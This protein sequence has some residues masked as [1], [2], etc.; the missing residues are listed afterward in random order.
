[1]G[2]ERVFV[3]QGLEELAANG[4]YAGSSISVISRNQTDCLREQ[5][6]HLILKDQRHS[7]V[8]YAYAG[9]FTTSTTYSKA[10]GRILEGFAT[11]LYSN[12]LLFAKPQ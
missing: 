7:I 3:L 5:S 2:N 4:L 10:M 12:R 8:T 11:R 9:W 6:K 1:M